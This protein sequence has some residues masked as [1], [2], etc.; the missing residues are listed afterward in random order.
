MDNVVKITLRFPKARI[1]INNLILE[2]KGNCSSALLH[3]SIDY[4]IL[5]WGSTV[6]EFHTDETRCSAL[7]TA[8]YILLKFLENK[9]IKGKT[10]YIK[11]FRTD[12]ILFKS[13]QLKRNKNELECLRLTPALFDLLLQQIEC[14]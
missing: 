4:G 12:F 14:V 5:P 9:K 7:K 8:E 10:K 6:P 11:A 1:H 3:A 2:K 13:V